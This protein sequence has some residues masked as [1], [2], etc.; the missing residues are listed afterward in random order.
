MDTRLIES[1]KEDA[2]AQALKRIAM[3][4]NQDLLFV[5][6]DGYIIYRGCVYS[7]FNEAKRMFYELYCEDPAAGY[8]DLRFWFRTTFYSPGVDEEHTRRWFRSYHCSRLR[9][10]SDRHGAESDSTSSGML[11]IKECRRSNRLTA[12]ES[13]YTR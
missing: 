9:T 7:P 10:N 11:V 5:D 12:M 1:Y 8:S 3:T 6:E 2:L 4:F 13:R